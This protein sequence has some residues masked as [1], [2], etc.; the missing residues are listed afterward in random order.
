MGEVWGLRDLEGNVRPNWTVY[1]TFSLGQKYD[2]DPHTKCFYFYAG[3]RT[4]RYDP[5]AREWKDLAP[6]SDPQR[7]LGGKSLSAQ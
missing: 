7:E 1:G 5:A 6:A 3:G 2:Y 4:F